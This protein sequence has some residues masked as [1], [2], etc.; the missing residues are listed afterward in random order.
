[1]AGEAGAG[2]PAEG[3]G[4]AGGPWYAPL[5]GEERGWAE[6][7]NYPDLA[8][9]VKAHRGLEQH[10]GVPRERLVKL[11]EKEDA[12]EWGEVF[13]RIGRPKDAAGYE[14][15]GAD[16]ELLAALHKE[17][18]TK[19]QAKNLAATITAR[20]QAQQEKDG[21]ASQAELAAEDAALRREWGGAYDENVKHGQQLLQRIFEKVG[22]TSKEEADQ[23]LDAMQKSAGKGGY[24]KVMKFFAVLG[25]GTAESRFI[26]GEGGGDFGMTP[27]AAQAEIDKL[28]TDGAFWADYNAGKQGA[29]EK[30]R[31]LAEIAG[32]NRST[33]GPPGGGRQSF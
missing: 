6:N 22:F 12:P 1:M 31:K 7:K 9:A 17:G 2:A 3:Q 15:E 33:G 10:L 21:Q 23:F 20:A 27:D 16:P 30:F 25:R 18:L 8:S 4:G 19:R 26:E 24:T 13:D 28:R 14:I 29:I 11:P 32:Q 5:Q